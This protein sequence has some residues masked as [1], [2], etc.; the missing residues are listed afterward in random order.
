MTDRKPKAIALLSGGLDSMLATKMMADQDVDV[1]AV[2]F[3][4]PFCSCGKGNCDSAKASE[5]LGVEVRHVPVGGDYIEL[6]RNPKHGRGRHMN[7]CIDCRIYMLEKAKTMMEQEGADFIVTG[8]V[9]GERPMSQH[10]DALGL[11]EREAGLEGKLLRPLSAKLLPETEPEREGLVDREN[12]SDIRGRSRKPQMAL[13]EALDIGPYPSPAGGCLLTDAA[14]SAKLQDLFDHDQMSMR[15]VVSLK[16]GRHFRL[17]TGEKII[18]G[19]NQE[20]NGRLELMLR[21][22]GRRFQSTDSKGSLVF[23]LD[24]DGEP[25]RR[26]AARIA[27]RYSRHRD[28]NSVSV[29]GWTDTEGDEFVLEAAPMGDAELEAIRL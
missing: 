16:F 13:A 23:L 21:S 22:E 5:Q 24:G 10:R 26:T 2:N 4:T 8:E 17:T 18:S 14:F 25:P 29:R 27:A 1:V 20:E 12:L 19:R 9:V 6:V 3:M 28:V 7:M 11:I 15:R